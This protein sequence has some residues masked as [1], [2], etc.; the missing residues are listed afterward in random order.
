M[1]PLFD[2]M[3]RPISQD[4]RKVSFS[5]RGSPSLRKSSSDNLNNE[6]QRSG[7]L[8]SVVESQYENSSNK[9]DQGSQGSISKGQGHDENSSGNQ[10]RDGKALTSGSADGSNEKSS[11][12]A[13]AKSGEGQRSD[14]NS[15]P[16]DKKSSE[17]GSS[18]RN[19]STPTNSGNKR[20]R[21]YVDADMQTEIGSCH[22]DGSGDDSGNEAD[23]D[24]YLENVSF[25]GG[26]SRIS[27]VDGPPSRE[28]MQRNLAQMMAQHLVQAALLAGAK[29]NTSVMIVLLPGCGL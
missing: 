22:D 25:P 3:N 18:N 12:S 23:I 1:R 21:R 29:D 19:Q 26:I 13:S 14:A 4:T 15:S 16:N 10:N 6:R 20:S 11:R 24:S 28:Q 9:S 7:T 2:E 5:S 8:E 27:M 17:N